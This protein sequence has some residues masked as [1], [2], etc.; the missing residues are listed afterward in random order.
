M[1]RVTSGNGT[2]QKKNHIREN[3]G[4]SISLFSFPKSL[5][6]FNQKKMLILFEQSFVIKIPTICH[7][8]IALQYDTFCYVNGI[9]GFFKL[10]FF[11]VIK[12]ICTFKLLR[13]LL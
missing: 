1:Y 12:K 8:Q 7:V 6:K 9:I 2:T 4:C 10:L 5:K 13:L 3:T 11:S